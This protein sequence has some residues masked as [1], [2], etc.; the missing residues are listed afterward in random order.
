MLGPDSNRVDRAVIRDPARSV[1][2]AQL[3]EI[4]R[5]PA[6]NRLADPCELCTFRHG[7]GRPCL[8]PRLLAPGECED[9]LKA[10]HPWSE[11]ANK[12][13]AGADKLVARAKEA[14]SARRQARRLAGNAE[15][16]QTRKRVWRAK[17][18][19]EPYPR[20]GPR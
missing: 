4:E 7:V 1:V 19:R 6:G 2:A 12:G 17:A 15:T 18:A 13:V 11:M 20:R 9:G 14:A 16:V 5:E 8:A 10:R 3:A